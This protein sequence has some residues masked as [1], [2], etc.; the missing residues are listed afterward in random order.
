MTNNFGN[1]IHKLLEI[2]CEKNFR[3]ANYLGYDVTYISKWINGNKLPSKK[4]L[5]KL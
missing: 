1:T 4:I 2:T 3:L 5:L